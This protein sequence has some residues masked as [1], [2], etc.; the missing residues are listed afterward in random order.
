MLKNGKKFLKKAL[1]NQKKR[2]RIKYNKP[3][4]QKKDE[5]VF[6]FSERGAV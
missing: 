3:M 6:P 5:Q 1:T 4:K 2:D